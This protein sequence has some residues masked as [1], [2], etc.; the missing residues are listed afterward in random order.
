MYLYGPLAAHLYTGENQT[1]AIHYTLAYPIS[2]PDT[3]EIST[4]TPQ[5]PM[6][7][8]RSLKPLASDLRWPAS[9]A[10]P[11]VELELGVDAFGVR[12]HHPVDLA[13]SMCTDFTAEDQASILSMVNARLITASRFDLAWADS[14]GEAEPS[15]RDLEIRSRVMGMLASV[16]D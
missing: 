2:V 11:E 5:G 4:P 6:V 16:R 15:P 10:L 12:A 14:L 9:C 13:V 7:M 3:F 8:R 1:G